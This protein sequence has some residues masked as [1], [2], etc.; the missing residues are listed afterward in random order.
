MLSKRDN[1]IDLD[2]SSVNSSMAV[3]NACIT[4][5]TQVVALAG[6]G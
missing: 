4:S 5:F 6:P 1:H 2:T 3:C